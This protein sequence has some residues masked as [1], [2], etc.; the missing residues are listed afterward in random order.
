MISNENRNVTPKELNGLW[1]EINLFL[2]IIIVSSN[3]KKGLTEKIQS[4]KRKFSHKYINLYL[5]KI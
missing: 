5:F 4:F 3:K 2:Y 1:W